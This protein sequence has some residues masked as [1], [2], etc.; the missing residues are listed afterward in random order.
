M[1]SSFAHGFWLGVGLSAGADGEE[2]IMLAEA[3]I[4]NAGLDPAQLQQIAT[5]ETRRHHPALLALASR[6]QV[7]LALFEAIVLE[8]ETPRLKNPSEALF[9]RIGCHG[10]AEA[11][12]LAAAG[13]QAALL[14]E[15]TTGRQV[16]VA[17]AAK[18]H[19]H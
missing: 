16:T 7:P 3:V 8:D 19:N 11:A 13:A 1:P 2:V 9:A 5:I 14:V 4:A 17:I 18:P 15:K 6:F 12:A 10:V